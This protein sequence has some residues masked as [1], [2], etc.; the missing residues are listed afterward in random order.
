MLKRGD[1]PEEIARYANVHIASVARRF[2]RLPK[3]VRD[4]IV[5]CR[6]GESFHFWQLKTREKIN[7]TV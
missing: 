1:H 3:Q 7:A 6:G 4:E 2:E 5:R